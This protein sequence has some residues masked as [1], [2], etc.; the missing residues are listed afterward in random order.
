[1]KHSNE[2]DKQNYNW[3]GL[4]KDIDNF[5]SKCDI[6]QKFKVCRKNPSQ[7]FVVTEAP[8]TPFERICIHILEIPVKNYILT[9]NLS[10]SLKHQKPHSK[11]EV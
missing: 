2:V 3:A 4:N 5:T 10:L 8:K 11:A 6:R 7:S 1:M 9:I